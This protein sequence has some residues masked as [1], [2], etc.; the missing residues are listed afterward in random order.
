MAPLVLG[1]VLRDLLEKS[2]RRGLV[3]ADGDVTPFFTRPISAF[4]CALIAVIILSRIPAVQRLVFRK[5]T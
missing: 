5:A 2:L 4:L 3:L 1:L